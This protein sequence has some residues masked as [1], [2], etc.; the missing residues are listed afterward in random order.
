MELKV[1][2]SK[3]YCI[4]AGLFS[5]ASCNMWVRRRRPISE[6]RSLTTGQENVCS[7]HFLLE[8][9][10]AHA[11][12]RIALVVCSL[13]WF[14]FLVSVHQYI[15]AQ[16]MDEGTSVGWLGA[17]HQR[18]A[19]KVGAMATCESNVEVSKTLSQSMR[20]SIRRSHSPT[21]AAQSSAGESCD[22]SQ[23][24]GVQVRG[25][26]RRTWRREKCSRKTSA[27]CSEDG[28][29]PVHVPCAMRGWN[30]VGSSSNGPRN[31]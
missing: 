9:V 11:R 21:E 27:R 28:Q 13:F 14:G 20:C 17:N 12:L 30:H 6:T 19:P 29:S 22:G 16:R 8:A 3:T 15:D 24:R 1:D 31:A 23:R 2:T 7:S 4:N 25:R 18:P 26:S 10:V 5:A